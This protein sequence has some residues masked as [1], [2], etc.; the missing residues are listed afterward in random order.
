MLR[1]IN[2]REIEMLEK[3]HDTFNLHKNVKEAAG[4][5]RPRTIGCFTD[6]DGEL[7]VEKQ[8]TIYSLLK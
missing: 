1:E 2:G 7:I 6:D 5:Y 8:T 3:K 4:L